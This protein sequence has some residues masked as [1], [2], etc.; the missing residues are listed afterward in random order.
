MPLVR[1]AFVLCLSF[2]IITTAPTHANTDDTPSVT[3]TWVGCGISKKAYM[4]EA[5][6]LYAQKTGV[7]I[8]IDG[9][10]ATKGIRQVSG[11]EADIG[12]TCRFTLPNNAEEKDT[13]LVP[14]AWDALVVIAHPD[15]PVSNLTLDQVRAVYE[16]NITNWRELGGKDAPIHLLARAGKVSGV[17]R[18]VR[19][20]VF[21][22]YDKEFPTAE[23]LAST[24]PLEKAVETD[25]NA[26]GITGISSARKRNVRILTLEG[27]DP[28]Y[29][30]IL[31]GD[32]LL[33]RPLYLGYKRDGR[34]VAQVT[35]FIQFIH[36]AEGQ[37]VLRANG[38]VPY[39]EGIHLVRKK[40]DQARLARERGL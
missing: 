23:L 15:N 30:N 7:K 38:T 16:G 18:T 40:L 35:H 13:T 26:I 2:S 4:D 29:D 8:A 17:G 24:G 6:A 39:L 36:G 28:S 32:Y 19:Q 25:P 3:L 34:H 1:S 21:A 37:A 22:D 12:G 5:A 20:L 10:G 31:S 11:G 9:G 14:V 27:K 33:Y